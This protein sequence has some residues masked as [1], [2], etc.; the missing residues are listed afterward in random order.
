[1]VEGF[2]GEVVQGAW[3]WNPGEK[4]RLALCLSGLPDGPWEVPPPKRLT[5]SAKAN[6]YYWS[7]VLR[8][9]AKHS[10]NTTDEIH[11]AMCEMFLPNERRHVE[12]FNRMTGQSLAVEIDPRRSSKLTGGPFY[13]FV[14]Q[15]RLWGLEFLG[16]TTPDP[17]PNYWRRA[18]RVRA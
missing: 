9:L 10:G 2:K 14:E 15:V 3:R 11:D 13:D 4:R 18:Q 16:V 7:T 12:F 8:E 1:M 5:R 17:D 6:A